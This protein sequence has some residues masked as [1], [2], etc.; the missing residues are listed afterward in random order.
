MLNEVRRESARVRDALMAMKCVR[1]IE[2]GAVPRLPSLA[3]LVR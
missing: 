3:R 1:S 2:L